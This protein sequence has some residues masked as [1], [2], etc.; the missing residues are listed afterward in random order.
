MVLS[1]PEGLLRIA[2]AD[3]KAAE[4][5]TNPAVF[6]EGAWGSWLQQAVEKTIKAWLL[7]LGGDH[8]LS[9]DLRRRLFLR[10]ADG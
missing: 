10:E 6:R 5:S 4:A 2:V 3:L 8:P 1:E 9:H 7:Q